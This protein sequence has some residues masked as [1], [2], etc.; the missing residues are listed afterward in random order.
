MISSVFVDRP[1]LAVVI[2][3]IMTLAGALSLLVPRVAVR[4]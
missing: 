4:P 3:I 1:R 2:A